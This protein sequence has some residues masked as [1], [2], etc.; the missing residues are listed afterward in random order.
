MGLVVVW[1]GAIKHYVFIVRSLAPC[2]PKCNISQCTTEIILKLLE[3]LWVLDCLVVNCCEYAFKVKLLHN[4][5]LRCFVNTDQDVRSF[6]F[7]RVDSSLLLG[8]CEFSNKGIKDS[9][10]IFV[11]ICCTVLEQTWCTVFSMPKKSGHKI[12]FPYW[13][14]KIPM[15]LEAFY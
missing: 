8:Q 14:L 1:G 6:T 10:N 13:N 15:E 2:S 12:G 3:V 11:N 9:C 5:A 7:L 4:V